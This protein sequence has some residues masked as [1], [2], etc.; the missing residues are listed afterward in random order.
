MVI[1]VLLILASLSGISLATGLSEL[2]LF[3]DQKWKLGAYGA[4]IGLMI[5]FA[6]FSAE[7]ILSHKRAFA[8]TTPPDFSRMGGHC[9]VYL[10]RALVHFYR[11]DWDP[12]IENVM[13]EYATE[14]ECRQRHFLEIQKLESAQCHGLADQ[15]GCSIHFMQQFA[16][17]GFWNVSDRKMF[18]NSIRQFWAEKHLPGSEAKIDPA[19]WEQYLITDH[20]LESSR[21][22]ILGMLGMREN[23]SPRY[24]Y[25]KDQ[26]DL[27]HLIT[28]RTIV[29]EFLKMNLTDLEYEDEATR[30]QYENT[31]DQI[32]DELKR[33]DELKREIEVFR[34]KN[35]ST[36]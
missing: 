30:E 32:E 4:T 11:M 20:Q 23:L 10:G 16:K 26:E 14:S 22:G 13:H 34:Q 19:I 18:F 6:L 35:E 24:I 8:E 12:T 21:T 17:N 2:S 7:D 1:L 31:V 5:F 27:E 9:G 28:T 15:V 25:L 3:S 33:I 29:E 36:H